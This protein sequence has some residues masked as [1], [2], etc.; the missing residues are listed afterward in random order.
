MQEKDFECHSGFEIEEEREDESRLQQSNA[1]QQTHDWGAR[2]RIEFVHP[3]V[4]TSR[5]FSHI[6]WGLEETGN[7]GF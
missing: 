1:A 6:D 3:A 2:R 7:S 4:G 5:P